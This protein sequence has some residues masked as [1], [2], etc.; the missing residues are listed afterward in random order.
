MMVRLARTEAKREVEVRRSDIV[1][2]V[3]ENG[4]WRECVVMKMVVETKGQDVAK[5]EKY[6]QTQEGRVHARPSLS[7]R[8]FG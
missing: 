7:S 6:S 3:S 5:K 8:Q 1:A 2:F 4:L